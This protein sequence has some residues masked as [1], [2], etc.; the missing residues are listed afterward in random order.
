M[1]IDTPL[2][3]NEELEEIIQTTQFSHTDQLEIMEA[4]FAEDETY[5]EY[6]DLIELELHSEKD[7]E[8]H[9]EILDESMDEPVTNLEEI[10]EFEFEIIEYLDN[11]SPHPPPKEPIFLRDNFGNLDENSAMAPLTS[12]FSTSQPNDNLIQDNGGIEVNLSLS[13]SYHYEYWLVF[14][15]DSH[16][17]QSIKTLHGLSNS[18]VWL[19]RG[20]CMILGWFFLIRNSKSIKLGKGSSTSDPGQGCFKHLW[21]HSIHCMVGCNVS[22]TLLFYFKFCIISFDCRVMLL[23]FF[24]ISKF[25]LCNYCQ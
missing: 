8:V 13:V 12:S 24:I 19:N 4:P 22:L 14:H 9:R 15:L 18:N 6:P 23:I 7:R 20:R 10:K 16:V 17:Q 1:K 5:I 11:S 25:H 3:P 2:D 21:F